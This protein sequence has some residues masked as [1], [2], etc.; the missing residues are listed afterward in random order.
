MFKNEI[1][2][3]LNAAYAANVKTIALASARDAAE[4]ARVAVAAADAQS[5]DS[6][7][8]RRTAQVADALALNGNTIDARTASRAAADAWYFAARAARIA[9]NG[10]VATRAWQTYFDWLALGRDLGIAT[11][12]A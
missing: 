8:V 5:K 4:V 9:E 1:R 3:T 10:S 6:G 12:P 2:A 7:F 11:N